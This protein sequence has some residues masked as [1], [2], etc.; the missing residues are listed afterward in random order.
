MTSADL[1][2]SEFLS[3]T[4]EQALANSWLEIIAVV[5]GVAYLLLAMRE[6][7]L[8]WYAAFISTLLFL[9]VFWDVKLYMESGLQLYYLA[10]AVYGWYKWRQGEN[11]TTLSI[12][13]WPLNRHLLIILGT[14]IVSGVSGYGLATQTDARFPYL[15]SFTTWGAVVTTYMVATKVL[16][17][18]LYWFVLDALS[19]YLYLDRGLY[20]A[21]LLFA[22]YLIIVIFGFLQW[23]RRY[24]QQTQS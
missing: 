15:D 8:C 14:V 17:N 11:N 1:L 9:I 18:W 13:R 21:A 6:N 4:L 10:M 2:M 24:L 3:V 19:I 5:M 16:E 7:I 22:A 12:K 23:N 20:F